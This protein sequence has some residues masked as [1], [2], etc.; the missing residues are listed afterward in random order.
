MGVR[1]DE[2]KL[3]VSQAAE[4]KMA[5]RRG[6]WTK[7]DIKELSSGKT[8]KEVLVFMRELNDELRVLNNL[9][10]KISYRKKKYEDL[11]DC[12]KI[13]SIDE[14]MMP[15]K[16]IYSDFLKEDVLKVLNRLSPDECH[17]IKLFFGIDC[18]DGQSKCY[19]ILAKES[20]LSVSAVQSITE[21]GIYKL[22][23]YVNAKFL[24]EYLA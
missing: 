7:K 10:K 19:D 20:G 18:I 24:Q 2:L 4:L 16:I 17:F 11:T 9:S 22:H 3:D 23:E 1:K 6:G 13:A 8:A 21:S 12:K 5:F 14:A 15:E